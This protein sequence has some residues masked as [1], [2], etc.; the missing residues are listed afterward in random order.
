MLFKDLLSSLNIRTNKTQTPNNINIGKNKTHTPNN[1]NILKN[2]T[3]TPNSSSSHFGVNISKINWL[4][5]DKTIYNISSISI[6]GPFLM[7]VFKLH[8]II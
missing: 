8:W 6:K 1:I 5:S 2:K 3:H 4:I 7:S